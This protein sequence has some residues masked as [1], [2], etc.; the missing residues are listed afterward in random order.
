MPYQNLTSPNTD[1]Y[2]IDRSRHA[3]LAAAVDAYLAGRPVLLLDDSD[4]E[5]EADIVAAAENLTLDT[6]VQMIRD[7]SGIVC[8]CLTS[9]DV[10]HLG[11][12][13]MVRNNQAV[14]RTGFTV[15]IEA[16]E[17]VTT[18]VSALDRTTTIQAAM[19]SLGDGP[20]QIVSPG[21]V[22]PLRARAGGVLERRGHT[23]GSIELSSIAGMQPA[24]VLC[25]LMNNDGTMATDGD[26]QRYAERYDMPIL[27]I[28]EIARYRSE[29]QAQCA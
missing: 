7:G 21:H 22:F 3:R 23:E 29:Q 18:G 17:G 2:P 12:E 19:A 9:D 5:N 20:R 1:C 4:R 10:D 27:T 16:S 8:L 14:N 24:A 6:M 26:I 11:L 15:S 13:Q 28:D 25:E